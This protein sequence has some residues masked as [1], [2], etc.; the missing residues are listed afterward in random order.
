M[1]KCEHPED[2][3]RESRTKLDPPKNHCLTSLILRGGVDYEGLNKPVTP[4][5][6]HTTQ[7]IR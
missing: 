7:S 4:T 3:P 1:D 6:Y 2:Y 5:I